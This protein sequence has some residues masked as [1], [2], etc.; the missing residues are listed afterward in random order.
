MKKLLTLLILVVLSII[1]IGCKNQPDP[2]QE[3][4]ATEP[5][6]QVTPDP[7]EEP[8]DEPDDPTPDDSPDEE[9]SPAPQPQPEDPGCVVTELGVLIQRVRELPSLN[10]YVIAGL[11]SDVSVPVH[12]IVE[13]EDGN[14]WYNVTVINNGQKIR[15]FVAGNIGDYQYARPADCN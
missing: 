8:T 3:P 15:G 1:L 5:P 11:V 7:T 4:G 6:S 13:D 14:T 10:S 2:T 12:Q 9:P